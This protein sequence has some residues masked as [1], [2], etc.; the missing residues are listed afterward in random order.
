[1]KGKL[2][3][4]IGL[5]SLNFFAGTYVNIAAPNLNIMKAALNIDDLLMGLVGT[6][7]ALTAL[8]TC[9]LSGVLPKYMKTKTIIYMACAFFLIGGLGP[10]FTT[11]IMVILT[12][13]AIMGL[14]VGFVMT[15]ALALVPSYFEGQAMATMMGL[16]NAVAGVFATLAAIVAGILGAISWQTP[17]WIYA[18]VVLVFLI[19]MFL[20]PEP[21]KAQA[22]ADGKPGALSPLAYVYGVSMLAIFAAIF[23]IINSIAGFLAGEKLADQ[24]TIGLAVALLTVGSFLASLFFGQLFAALKKWT[25]TFS[26]VFGTVGIL[27]LAS[28]QSFAVACAGI[29]ILGVCLGLVVPTVMTK[30]TIASPLNATVATSLAMAGILVGQFLSAFLMKA[31]LSILHTEAYRP[32]ILVDGFIMAACLVIAIFG[33]LRSKNPEAPPPAHHSA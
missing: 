18:G 9:L 3:I 4:I 11:N 8:V 28:A 2:L 27:V 19:I 25:L 16:Q 12:F 20:L 21:P 31:I 26:L 23:L 30:T 6:L 1:M 22:A 13:R 29:L 17:Y 14:G 10:I 24:A 32:M 7:P 33:A 15:Y 5:M